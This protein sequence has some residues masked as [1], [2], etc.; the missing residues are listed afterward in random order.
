MNISQ[1]DLEVMAIG[2]SSSRD[3]TDSFT[4]FKEIYDV[5]DL[6]LFTSFIKA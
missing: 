6:I 3:E 2:M 5:E 4:I 1:W